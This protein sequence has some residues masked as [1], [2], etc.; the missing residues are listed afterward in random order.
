M[1]VKSSSESSSTQR[2]VCRRTPWKSSRTRSSGRS[3]VSACQR[4]LSASKSG[5]VT[6][7]CPTA[8]RPWSTWTSK[9]TSSASH[10]LMC[11]RI[12]RTDHSPTALGCW[13]CSGVSPSMASSNADRLAS[14]AERISCLLISFSALTSLSGGLTPSGGEVLGRSRR[15]P[16]DWGRSGVRRGRRG[17][18]ASAQGGQGPLH[19]RHGAAESGF[20]ALEL[21]REH[22][23]RQ[24]LVVQVLQTH[25]AAHVLDVDA[26]V[27]E[28]LVHLVGAELG[29]DPRPH[30]LPVLE[31]SLAEETPDRKVHRVIGRDHVDAPDVD[32]L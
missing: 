22:A 11:C 23:Q 10:R 31:A 7:L 12:S 15:A 14:R 3:F 30:L 8:R 2:S 21:P 32:L 17:R 27:G 13:R 19:P 24:A 20:A 28:E 18:A 5:L 4:A 25:V 6:K 29:V 9:R 1:R 26:V 16:F